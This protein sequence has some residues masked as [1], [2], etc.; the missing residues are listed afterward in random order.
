MYMEITILS[1]VIDEKPEIPQ[2]VKTFPAFY[3]V[4]L[5]IIFNTFA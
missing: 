1:S 2:L 3:T 4:F 5:I